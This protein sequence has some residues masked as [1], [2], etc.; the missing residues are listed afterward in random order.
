MTAR[1]RK[2]GV[3]LESK[4]WEDVRQPEYASEFISGRDQFRHI[5]ALAGQGEAERKSGKLF[6]SI[7]FE[8][9]SF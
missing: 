7:I 5:S 9:P 8:R 3:V 1:S 4:S 2:I 6:R